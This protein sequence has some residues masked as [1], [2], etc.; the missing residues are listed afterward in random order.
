MNEQSYKNI[1]ITDQL[2]KCERS[3][4]RS[5]VICENYMDIQSEVILEERCKYIEHRFSAECHQLLAG[6]GVNGHRLVKLGLGGAH[7][8]GNRKTL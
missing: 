2:D 6:G 4:N 7:L 1:S 5:R 8:D 3:K